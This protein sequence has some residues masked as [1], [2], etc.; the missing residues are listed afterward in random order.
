MDKCAAL[1]IFAVWLA[2]C[3]SKPQ[4]SPTPSPPRTQATDP[5]NRVGNEIAQAATTPLNDLNLVNA[6]IPS[7]AVI[8]LIALA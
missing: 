8:T 6:P 1:C 2:A 3:G 7:A 5:V 4:A